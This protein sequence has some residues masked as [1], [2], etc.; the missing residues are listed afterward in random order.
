MLPTKFR[1]NWLFGLGE[2]A[3]NTL[4]IFNLQVTLMLSTKFQV[5]WIYGS[6]EVVKNTWIS[7]PNDFSYFLT[8]KSHR[9]FL[10]CIKPILS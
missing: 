5:N 4:A 1:V 2:E 9:C 10:P 8:Y 7:D 3:Q 6:G